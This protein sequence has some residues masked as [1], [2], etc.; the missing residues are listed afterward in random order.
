MIGRGVVLGEVAELL[1]RDGRAEEVLQRLDDVLLA[2]CERPRLRE[3]VEAAV[4][5][6]GHAKASNTKDASIPRHALAGAATCTG[7]L[8]DESMRIYR[9]SCKI[10]TTEQGG[11]KPAGPRLA[12]LNNNPFSRKPPPHKGKDT[13]THASLTRARHTRMSNWDCSSTPRP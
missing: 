11:C 13:G 1:R 6:D 10:H 9:L 7:G 4:G 12:L 2:G 3:R 5:H 8:F